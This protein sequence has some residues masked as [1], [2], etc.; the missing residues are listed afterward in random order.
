MKNWKMT[1]GPGPEPDDDEALRDLMRSDFVLEAHDRAAVGKPRSLMLEGFDRPFV[2]LAPS[3]GRDEQDARRGASDRRDGMSVNRLIGRVSEIKSLTGPANSH[4]VDELAAALFEEASNFAPAIEAIRRSAQVIIRRG[5]QWLQFR[6]L[7]I[8]SAAGAGKT[9][10]VHR[11]AALSGLKL[12]Y[13]DC[14]TMTNMSPIISQDATWSGARHSEI[15]EGLANSTSAN[16]IVCLDELDKIRD[17]GRHSSPQPSQALVGL[18]EK[19]S[20]ASHLDNY[21]QLTVDLSFINWVILVNDLSRISQPLLDRCQVI[22]L[23]PPSPRDIAHIASLEIERRGLE[24]GL[25]TTITK[26]VRSGKI[27][28]LRTLQKLLDAADAA[29][30]RSILN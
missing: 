10:F 7:V 20:A 23:P 5:A 19:Q 26:A 3:V 1:S 11:L 2:R 13:L 25:V 12:V 6:P 29:S 15:I 8:E 24:P 9:R 16:L 28:S 14:A 4:A 22:R 17:F 27:T 18:F 21:L 30:A